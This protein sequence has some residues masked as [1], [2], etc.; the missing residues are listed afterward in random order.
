M[1]FTFRRATAEDAELLARM[2]LEM[3]KERETANRCR[4]FLCHTE[5]F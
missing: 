3:R 4:T 5:D 1:V 2:R